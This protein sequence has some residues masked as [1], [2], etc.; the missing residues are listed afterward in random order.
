MIKNKDET[1]AMIEHI[2]CDC[3]CKFNSKTCNSNQKWNN[4]TNQCE[5]KHYRKCKKDYS[6]N[7]AHVP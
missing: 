4:K 6:W 2:S 1:K 5:C 3:K 7:V